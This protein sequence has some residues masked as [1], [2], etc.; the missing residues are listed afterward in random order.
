MASVICSPGLASQV[1]EGDDILFRV[2][3]VGFNTGRPRTK[4]EVVEAIF[5]VVAF[6]SSIFFPSVAGTPPPTPLL[7]PPPP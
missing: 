1:A 2:L 3:S 6:F 5:D 7:L 4:G